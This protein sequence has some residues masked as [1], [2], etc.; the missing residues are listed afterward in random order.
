MA[1]DGFPRRTMA[2]LLLLAVAV[3]VFASLGRWQLQ[4]AEE[5]RALA[6]AIEAGRQ[7]PPVAL[8]PGMDP[9][10]LQPWRP[11]RASGQWRHDL[12]VLLDNRNLDGRPGLWLATPL[13]LDA[14]R[15]TA[16]L[17]LRG[18][19]PRPLDGGAPP[20]WPEPVGEQTV[21]GELAAH[22]PRLFEL[23]G[24]RGQGLPQDWPGGPPPRMQNL[25]LDELAR[26]SGLA[27]LPAVLMQQGPDGDGLLRQWPLPGLDA[28][29]NVGYALQ[30][31]SFAAI[32]AIAWLVVAINAWR[33]RSG[34]ATS[35]AHDPG[36]KP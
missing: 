36:D 16:V 24:A 12:S 35:S 21:T 6:Q 32:A 18:W 2:A 14:A 29:K 27:F 31:F 22:V 13:M 26:A 9:G 3:G 25:E 23:P 20:A 33:R 15:G 8:T 17:V 10:L 19:L 11:A 28:D 30:W 4:R 7:A 34:R 5:R 1:M